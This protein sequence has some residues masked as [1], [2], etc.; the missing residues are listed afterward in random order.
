M[1]ELPAPTTA[2]QRAAAARAEKNHVEEAKWLRQY[3]LLRPDDTDVMV[4]LA[5]ASDEAAK[6]A[7]GYEQLQ[8]GDE[9]RRQLGRALSE[10]ASKGGQGQREVEIRR[11]IIARLIASFWFKEAERQL[12]KLDPELEDAE[13]LGWLA[14]SLASIF[15]YLACLF[16]QHQ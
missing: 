13:A 7:T 15:R 2:R 12:V 16:H 4:E 9:A 6:N 8:L 11:R 1:S 10:V 14:L 3:S 5:I